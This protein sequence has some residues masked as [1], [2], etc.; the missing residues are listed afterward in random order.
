MLLRAHC[1]R[2]VTFALQAS[3][4]PLMRHGDALGA[5][6]ALVGDETVDALCL[7]YDETGVQTSHIVERLTFA[8]LVRRAAASEG[9]LDHAWYLQWRGLP[10][11][12]PLAADATVETGEAGEA[13]ESAGAAVAPSRQWRRLPHPVQAA[14][15]AGGAGG[16]G[17]VGDAGAVCETAEAAEAIEAHS[18]AE[19][20]H[21]STSLAA[22]A[23]AEPSPSVRRPTAPPSALRG[24][25]ALSAAVRLPRQVAAAAVSEVTLTRTLTLA[26]ALSLSLSKPQ[27]Q[28]QPQPNPNQVNAWVGCSRTSHLHFDGL[29]NLLLVASGAKTVLLYSP[30]QYTE[31]YPQL[32]KDERWKSAARSRAY[33]ARRGSRHA[34]LVTEP[35]WQAEVLYLSYYGYAYY[36]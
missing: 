9:C 19:A 12:L 14:A 7:R 24:T 3:C 4:W 11:P 28:S 29:D 22:R 17:E 8:E 6:V 20:P 10:H 26:P 27:T 25:A 34:S 16:A 1:A 23:A 15:D 18:A 33:A 32:D 31:L 21:V 2:P 5:A 36:G 13:D 35:C 30:W